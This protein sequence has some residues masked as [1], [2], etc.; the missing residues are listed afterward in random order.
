MTVR[1]EH[2]CKC[3]KH[4]KHMR[5]RK[6]YCSVK[7]ANKFNPSRPWNDKQRNYKYLINYG[8]SLDDYNELF[9]LQD[10]KC[11]IC[12]MHQS[13]LKRNLHV[14]HNHETG[15][16]RGLLC[17]PCNHAIGLLKENP[18]IIKAALEYVS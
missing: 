18:K 6:M 12:E 15:E 10:G 2:I 16:V 3:G 11:K 9:N 4:F 5:K 7:C 14:D 1:Y 13:K 17:Q 8:I